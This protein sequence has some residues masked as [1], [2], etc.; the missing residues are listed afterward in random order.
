VSRTRLLRDSV[1]PRIGVKAS[2]RFRTA[3]QLLEAAAAGATR[4]SA[5][6]TPSLARQVGESAPAAAAAS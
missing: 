2:A 1:G 3:D 5:A 4:V 6:L